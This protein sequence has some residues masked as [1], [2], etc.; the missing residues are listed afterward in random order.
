MYSLQEKEH[1]ISVEQAYDILRK[2]EKQSKNYFLPEVE[3]LGGNPEGS[4]G[5]DSW[6]HLL[7]EL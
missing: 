6:D 2:W 7:F 4:G 1:D 5:G 3:C